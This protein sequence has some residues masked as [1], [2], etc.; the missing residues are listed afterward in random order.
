MS[1]PERELHGLLEVLGEVHHAEDLDGFRGALLD[2][3]PRV[4]PAAYTSYNEVGADGAPLVTLVSPEPATQILASWGRVGHQNPLVQHHLA[5]RDGRALRLSDVTDMAAFRELELYTDVF[6]PLGVEHQLAVTLPAPPTLLIG[7]VFA[8][9]D[10]FT[11]AQRR[12]LDLARPHLI[13]AHANAALRERMHD[14]LAAVEA[15]LDDI[16]EAVVVSDARDRIAFATRAGRAALELMGSRGDRL[17]ATLRDTPAPAHAVVPVDGGPLMVRRMAPRGGA[18]VF[19]FERGSRGAPLSLLESLGLTPREAEVLQAMMRGQSTAAV[20]ETLKVSPRT[21]HKHT[22]H[23]Y[24][25][26]GVTDRL[27]AVSAAWAALESGK[28]SST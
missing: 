2:V 18:T 12:M 14:V 26:L 3:L 1:L 9:A 13:Q 17:P 10:D 21:V 11:D 25:K 4:I 23:L 15:G 16:G 27:A 22:E 5:S 6:V 7:L 24:A 19:M 28:G 20:A 8:D